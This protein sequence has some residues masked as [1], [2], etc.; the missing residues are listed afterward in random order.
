VEEAVISTKALMN[1]LHFLE[2][3]WVGNGD[4]DRLFETIGEIRKELEKR[5][6]K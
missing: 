2:K 3:Q 4:Q 6:K 5:S 1:C